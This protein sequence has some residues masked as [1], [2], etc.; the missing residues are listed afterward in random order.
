MSDETV[1]GDSTER[2][3]P[4]LGG[5][6]AEAE[7]F[8]GPKLQAYMDNLLV[9]QFLQMEVWDTVIDGMPEQ[10]E[11]AVCYIL[12][13]ES[14]ELDAQNNIINLKWEDLGETPIFWSFLKKQILDQSSAETPW[15]LGT[16]SKGSRAYRLNPPRPEDARAA[17]KT[18]EE[19]RL[20]QEAD[21]T[22]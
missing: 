16:L 9:I 8:Q 13:V 1:F 5:G 20:I 11:T 21:E 17:A 2:P 12:V 19:W 4:S 10:S 22:F 14:Y 6:I 3:L 18:V 7:L 15:V